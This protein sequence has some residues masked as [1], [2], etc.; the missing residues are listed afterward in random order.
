MPRKFDLWFG[1]LLEDTKR[2]LVL[3]CFS[4]RELASLHQLQAKQRGSFLCLHDVF[5]SILAPHRNEVAALLQE[6]RGKLLNCRQRGYCSS[7]NDTKTSWA[8]HSKL[9]AAHSHG[10]QSILEAQSSDEFAYSVSFLLHRIQEHTRSLCSDAHG[11]AWETGSGTYIEKLSLCLPKGLQYRKRVLK[12]QDNCI[13]E[14]CDTREVEHFVLLNH[15]VE[16]VQQLVLCCIA[17]LKL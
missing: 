8:L 14:G 5:F 17:E 13:F 10:R 2:S 3:P 4:D 11:D 12:V 1:N 7:S 9:L 6:G 15:Q 16:V